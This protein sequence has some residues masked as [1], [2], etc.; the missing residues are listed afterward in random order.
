M[1]DSADIA[2]ALRYV[3]PVAGLGVTQRSGPPVVRCGD[4]DHCRWRPGQAGDT[5]TA[6]SSVTYP[7]PVTRSR[8]RPGGH[9]TVVR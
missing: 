7:R 3:D 1:G 6:A 2:V 4:H 5:V 9:A 8:C